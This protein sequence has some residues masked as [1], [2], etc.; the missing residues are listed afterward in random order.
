[1]ARD[2]GL[3]IACKGGLAW[4]GVALISNAVHGATL[5]IRQQRGAL[6]NLIASPGALGIGPAKGATCVCPCKST[7]GVAPYGSSN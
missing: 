3:T 2:S 5:I 4:P 7:L 6:P 1:M